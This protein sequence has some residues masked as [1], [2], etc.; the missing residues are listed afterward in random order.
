MKLIQP[1]DE[2][3]VGRSNLLDATNLIL[4]LRPRR[5]DIYENIT[6]DTDR[7]PF[8]SGKRVSCPIDT[9]TAVVSPGETIAARAS[10]E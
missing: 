9:A 4:I 8:S 7:N 3:D 5:P 6:I 10:R 2:I 1:T